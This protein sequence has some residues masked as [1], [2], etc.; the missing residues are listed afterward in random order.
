M[1]IFK[2]IQFLNEFI[3]SYAFFAN[4]Y[5]LEM[6]NA[7]ATP[8]YSRQHDIPSYY[9][10][11]YA[12]TTVTVSFTHTTLQYCHEYEILPKIL[13]KISCVAQG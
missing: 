9:I 11:D 5:A 2:K 13:P 4:S 3:Y 7:C 12:P 10:S 8:Y 6:F 1:E